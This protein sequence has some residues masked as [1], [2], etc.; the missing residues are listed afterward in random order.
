MPPEEIRTARK[1]AP[2]L[3]SAD[4]DFYSAIADAL[5]DPGK[6]EELARISR[7]QTLPAIEPADSI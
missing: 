4:F 2:I 7:W 3:H 1:V 6:M 5:I